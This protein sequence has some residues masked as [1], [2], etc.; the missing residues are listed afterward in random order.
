MQPPKRQEKDQ[1]SH[2]REGSGHR[3]FE[4]ECCDTCGRSDSD[5]SYGI[6]CVIRSDRNFTKLSS[7]LFDTALGYC[8]C[9]PIFTTSVAAACG[10]EV[11]FSF[12]TAERMIRILLHLF[13]GRSKDHSTL[14]HHTDP[15]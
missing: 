3:I 1:R 2:N 10:S 14:P 6:G 11:K 12:E 9:A 4:G 15:L 7:S 5:I 8:V 13:S